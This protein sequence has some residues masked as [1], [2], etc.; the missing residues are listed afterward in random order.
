MMDRSGKSVNGEVC[1]VWTRIGILLVLGM[2]QVLQQSALAGAS[3]RML[4]S[5]AMFLSMVV[6]KELAGHRAQ[7]GFLA[8]AG[9][10]LLWMQYGLGSDVT[11]FWIDWCYELLGWCRAGVWWYLLPVGF[12]LLLSATEQGMGILCAILLGIIYAQHDFI[13]SSYQRQEQEEL[14]AE[15]SL[16]RSMHCREQELQEE[17]RR[18]LVEAENQ[19]LEERAELSQTLHDKL[20]HRINGSL[21]QLEAVKVLMDRDRETSQKMLQ[22]VIDNLRTG[23]DEIRLILRKERPPQ[24]QIAIRQLEKLCEECREKGIE[25]ELVTEGS[26]QAVPEKL[27]EILLDNAC[28]AVSNSLKY[29]DCSRIRISVHVLNQMLRCSIADNGKGFAEIAD[30][31]GIAG[32]RRRVRAVNGILDFETE[33]GFTINMLLPLGTV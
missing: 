33:A 17:V 18:G 20:G 1:F 7:I 3:I 16:K 27:L 19:M 9:G 6:L 2:Y 32:M 21:Y 28:E 14:L 10:I 11:L 15:Q 25:A 31:M 12:P 22:A 13:L 26:L 30:G 29:A 23:M 5:F 24:Y 4:L 8:A